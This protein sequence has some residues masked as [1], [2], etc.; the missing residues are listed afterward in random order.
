M[1]YT[2]TV[3]SLQNSYTSAKITSV[4]SDISALVRLGIISLECAARVTR[5]LA[6]VMYVY[7][8]RWYIDLRVS[9]G[10]QETC[11]G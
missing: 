2:P 7:I 10:M 6:F 11:Q 9:R 5:D 4:I 8:A 1:N 3:S